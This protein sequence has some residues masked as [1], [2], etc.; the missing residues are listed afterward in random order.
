MSRDE[1]ARLRELVRWLR[2]VN[3]DRASDV[4]TLMDEYE[5]LSRRQAEAK[6]EPKRREFQV[7]VSRRMAEALCLKLKGK[8]LE[9][10][11]HGFQWPFPAGEDEDQVW[12]NI[13]AEEGGA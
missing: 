1:L 13:E 9:R 12:V 11:V 8:S 10:S 2:M 6:A 4:E 3:T 5:T 7:K